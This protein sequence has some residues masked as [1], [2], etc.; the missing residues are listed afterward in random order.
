MYVERYGEPEP[1]QKAFIRTRQQRNGWE[2]EDRDL[3]EVL[4][5]GG[6]RSANGEV[7]KKSEIRTPNA[8][9]TGGGE[10]ELG[11][12]NGL[13]GLHKLQWPSGLHGLHGLPMEVVAGWLGRGVESG[14]TREWF[15]G[16]C[17]AIP[18]H[19]RSAKGRGLRNRECDMRNGD[20]GEGGRKGER[21]GL[22]RG[23]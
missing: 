13:E 2:S 6:I 14:C 16:G 21:R 19:R 22:W 11:W 10:V 9:W 20:A 3:S 23:S 7:R 1:E 8:P 17:L 5:V 12:L 18:S 15:R 4:A